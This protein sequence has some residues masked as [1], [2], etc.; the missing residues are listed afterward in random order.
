[1]YLFV[2]LVVTLHVGKADATA[3]K[4]RCYSK[5]RPTLHVAFF[6]LT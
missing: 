5:E 1:M 6:S 3:R 2:F 4:V